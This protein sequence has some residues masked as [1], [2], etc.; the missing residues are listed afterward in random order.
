MVIRLDAIQTAQVFFDENFGAGAETT[1]LGDEY[2]FIADLIT[3]NLR[4]EY[5]PIVLAVHPTQSSGS[6]WGTDQ[7]RKARALIFDRVFKGNRTLP[8]LARIAF[9]MRK[10]GRGLSLLQFVKFVIKR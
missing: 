2:I 7:D 8:Y 10:L 3:A 5:A 9:G 6:G 4:C 1:Y